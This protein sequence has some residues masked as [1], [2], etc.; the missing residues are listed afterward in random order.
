M[1]THII[2]LQFTTPDY[3]APLQEFIWKKIAST[4]YWKDTKLYKKVL[5]FIYTQYWGQIEISLSK[6][7]RI[8]CDR[9]IGIYLVKEKTKTHSVK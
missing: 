8:L 7:G 2:P 6:D 4:H 5:A 9:R 3:V 1:P